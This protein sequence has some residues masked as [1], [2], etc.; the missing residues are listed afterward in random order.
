MLNQSNS[1]EWLAGWAEMAHHVIRGMY[2]EEY[3]H[4]LAAYY[5]GESAEWRARHTAHH[6]GYL[7]ALAVAVGGF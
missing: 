2:S 7:A 6:D 3:L 5:A 1:R 4:N